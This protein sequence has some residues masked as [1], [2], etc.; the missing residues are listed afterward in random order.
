MKAVT[1][2]QPYAH[3]IVTPIGDLPKG[4][5]EKRIENR[6]WRT[7]YRGALAIH[8]GK[9]MEW[10]RGSGWPMPSGRRIKEDDFPEMA[11]GAVV[12]TAFLV[13]CVE[14]ARI[15]AGDYDANFPWYRNHAH[16]EGPWCW[17]L[18]AVKR[19][20]A[21]IPFVGKQGIYEIPDELLFTTL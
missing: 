12:G 15:R 6:T 4:Q 18:N 13:D 1:I 20:D 16:M 14:A 17:I 10:F 9:S 8:A 11:F 2:A 19:L 7:S 21:P 3:L 5:S